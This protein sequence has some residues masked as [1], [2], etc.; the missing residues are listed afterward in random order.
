MYF[1]NGLGGHG[2]TLQ[3]YLE[4]AFGRQNP[5]MPP[6]MVCRGHARPRLLCHGRSKDTARGQEAA[7]KTLENQASWRNGKE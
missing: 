3:G 5:A 4:A 1:K 6:G 2:A 7:G